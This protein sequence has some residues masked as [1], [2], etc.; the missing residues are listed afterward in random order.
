VADTPVTLEAVGVKT[1][2]ELYALPSS[3]VIKRMSTRSVPLHAGDAFLAVLVM[4][5]VADLAAASQRLDTAARFYR[6]WGFVLAVVA[7]AAA[8]VGVAVAITT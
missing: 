2:D 3:E 7:T 6:F 4:R 5:A 1:W 8:V